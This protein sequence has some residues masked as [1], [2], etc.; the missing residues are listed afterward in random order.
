MAR[1]AEHVAAP[2]AC[3]SLH[4][5]ALLEGERLAVLWRRRAVRGGQRGVPDLGC[6]FCWAG[7]CLARQL[8]SKRLSQRALSTVWLPTLTGVCAA[9]QIIHRDIK[10]EN[11]LLS[12]SGLMKLCDFGF[13]RVAARGE[14]LSEYV[15]TRCA[16]PSPG[17]GPES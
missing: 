2:A 8:A 14:A 5:A 11:M 3:G 17:A 6:H 13:A 1:G 9:L 10:P 4:G 15:A 7:I 12:C 16:A